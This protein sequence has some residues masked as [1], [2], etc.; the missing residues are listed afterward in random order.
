MTYRPRS[1]YRRRRR[2]N[3]LGVTILSLSTLLVVLLLIYFIVPKKEA[4]QDVDY[5]TPVELNVKEETTLYQEPE[6]YPKK[7]Y[8]DSGIDIPYPEDGVKGIYMSA[9]GYA[10]ANLKETNINL[11]KNSNLNAIVVDVKDDWG[12]I[13]FDFES[14]D[15]WI[16][17]NTDAVL[18]AK[19]TLKEFEANQIYPIARI[20]TFKDTNFAKKHPEHAFLRSDGSVWA[21]DGGE[22]FINPFK[23][24]VWDY[25]ISVAIEAAKAGFREIQFDYIRFAEGFSFVEPG[26]T[27]DMGKYAGREEPIDQ[28][29]VQVINDFIEYAKQKLEPYNVHIGIDIFG[30]TATV[31]EDSDIGQNFSK[32]AERGDV[33]SSMIYPSHWG[34]GYFGLPAPDLDPYTVVK[35]YIVSEMA[36]LGALEH[37]PITRPWLQDFTAS[38]LGGGMY[39]VYGPDQVKAQVQALKDVGINEFLLWNAANVYSNVQGDY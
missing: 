39:Q 2:I 6:K 15:P 28:L 20:V 26:L 38:Y 12:T 37:P 7:F 35:E 32:M 24:E 30:Y 5:E 27:Y 29:R 17:E 9:Y 11:I 1:D 31:P 10:N 34:A 23:Q 3:W 14:T 22:H 25:T 19:E 8:Y 13:L 4:I 18:N 33:V 16:L 21:N 36:I